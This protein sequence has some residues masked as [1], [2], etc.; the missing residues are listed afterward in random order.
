MLPNEEKHL[1]EV[2]GNPT[3]LTGH[4]IQ[5]EGTFFGLGYSESEILFSK[6]MFLKPK[7]LYVS[8]QL[9]ILY[10]SYV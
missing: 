5:T 3:T 2:V 8:I 10:T 6:S 4:R 9:A 1:L 7:Y